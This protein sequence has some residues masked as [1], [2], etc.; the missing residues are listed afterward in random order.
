MNYK[1]NK[2]SV[3]LF[4]VCANPWCIALPVGHPNCNNDNNNFSEMFTSTPSVLVAQ[5]N[6]YQSIERGQCHEE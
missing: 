4:P 2:N 3:P 1:H 5:V 6:V